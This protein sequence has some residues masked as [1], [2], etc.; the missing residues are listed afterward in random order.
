M[1][2]L[3]KIHHLWI[4]IF[5]TSRLR[6]EPLVDE[7]L[8]LLGEAEEELSLNLHRVDSFNGFV[9]LVVQGLNF[10]KRMP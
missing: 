8:R 5:F 10:L 3:M 6:D 9:N 1:L 2:T 4:I 7:E